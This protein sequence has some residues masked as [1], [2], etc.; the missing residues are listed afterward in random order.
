MYQ[1]VF[2]VILTTNNRSYVTTVTKTETGIEIEIGIEQFRS[3]ACSEFWSQ[4]ME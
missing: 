3:D 1:V 4:R 2:D